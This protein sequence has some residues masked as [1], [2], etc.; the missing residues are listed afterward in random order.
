MPVKLQC[1]RGTPLTPT[2]SKRRPGHD[3]SSPEGLS[4]HPSLRGESHKERRAVLKEHSFRAGLRQATMGHFF[5]CVCGVVSVAF[6]AFLINVI[7]ALQKSHRSCKPQGPA[8]S[9]CDPSSST[10]SFEA[11]TPC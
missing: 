1:Y 7:R 5:L 2:T 4:P 9:L 8:P 3:A 10:N 6:E 11:T